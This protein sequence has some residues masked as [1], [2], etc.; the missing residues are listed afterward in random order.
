MTAVVACTISCQCH[1]RPYDCRP[2]TSH[3]S[4]PHH[5]RSQSAGQA[6]EQQLAVT[7]RSASYQ[8]STGS[9]FDHATGGLFASEDIEQL[10]AL[11]EG[12]RAGRLHC[13]EDW[14]F[15]RD[16]QQQAAVQQDRS[17]HSSPLYL[18]C[19]SGSDAHDSNEVS[20]TAAVRHDSSSPL[21]HGDGIATAASVDAQSMQQNSSGIV[22]WVPELGSQSQSFT[23]YTK[24]QMDQTGAA[25]SV[26]KEVMFNA[27]ADRQ[28]S[29]SIPQGLSAHAWTAPQAAAVKAAAGSFSS[30]CGGSFSAEEGPHPP[31]APSPHAGWAH[32]TTGF[33]G[34]V[35]REDP[36]LRRFRE[37]RSAEL[38]CSLPQQGSQLIISRA[39]TH[40]AASL[41]DQSTSGH[42]LADVCNPQDKTTGNGG[43]SLSIESESVDHDIELSES[44][45]DAMKDRG[46]DGKQYWRAPPS[47]AWGAP[48]VTTSSSTAANVGWT[49]YC[50][51][52]DESS[53]SMVSEHAQQIVNVVRRGSSQEWSGASDCGAF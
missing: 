43:G 46:A 48:A 7:S 39:D 12:A 21:G 45:Q 28:Q 5:E 15:S 17:G 49:E 10:Y 23:E 25:G 52:S 1:D 41:K 36:R 50:S 29:S 19:S 37:A 24:H 40:T 42:V 32:A 51:D 14:E 47:L 18:S 8:P 16:T 27:Q 9:P 38:Q 2:S 6:L 31:F 35:R 11:P 34:R 30:A 13:S 4:K 26:R 22:F 33:R 53:T 20:S 44:T 3:R